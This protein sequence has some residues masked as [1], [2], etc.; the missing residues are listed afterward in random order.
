[1]TDNS[2]VRILLKDNF[3]DIYD[4]LEESGG[5][6]Y[7]NNAVNKWL[8]SLFI[9]GISQVYTYFIWDMLL[10][11][12]NIIIFKTLYA[13]IIILESH[14]IKCKTFD[15]LNNVFNEVPLTFDKRGKLAY[16]LISKK[17]NFNMEMIKKYRKTLN[18]RI[19]K[20]IVGLG[21][22]N[23]CSKD[24]DENEKSRDSSMEI[25]KKEECDLDWPICLHDQKNL[26]KE[27][28][29]I[30]LKQLQPPNVIDNYIDNYEEYKKMNSKNE[31]D[32]DNDNDSDNQELLNIKY[33]KDKKFQELLIERKKHF[34]GT[35]LM[36]ISENLTKS[37]INFEKIKQQEIRV[38][39]ISEEYFKKENTFDENTLVRNKTINQ[40]I[41][42]VA[43]DN[44]DK[45]TFVKE[46]VEK[47]LLKE[48]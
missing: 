34:C 8:L 36:S 14:I 19:I 6:L 46:N 26:E 32:N 45:I 16:Y 12:G 1:M 17:F 25:Q 29:H 21:V 24:T 33:Y 30:V 3:R 18:P 4:A 11:E 22:F 13:M 20:E 40:I 15:Q 10:L 37:S 44:H 23:R 48:Y 2:I 39:K 41:I 47:D 38:R 43:D 5:S 28:D 42:D 35:K 7:L 31:L 9:Q 27:Y